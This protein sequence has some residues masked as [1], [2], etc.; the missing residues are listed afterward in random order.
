M[1][2]KGEKMMFIIDLIKA[3]AIITGFLIGIILFMFLY[4]ISIWHF[5]K[6]V[7]DRN[8]E[9]PDDEISVTWIGH[10]TLL[11]N[12]H[13]TKILTDPMYSD[14]ILVFAKRYFEPGVP[15]EKL[16]DIDAIVISHEHYD[17]LD[18]ATLEQLSKDIPVIIRKG[19]SERVKEAGMKDIRELEWWESTE[20]KD[21]RITA[22]PAQHG[23]ANACG[24]VIEGEK[25]FYF[26]GDTGYF[27]A[28]EEIGKKFDLDVAFL[29]MSHYKSRHGR[30][31]VDKMLKRIHMGPA[32]F[33]DAIKDLGVELV[34]P[35]HYLTFRNVGIL[36]LPLDEPPRYMREISKKHGLEKIVKMLDIG[37]K[38]EISG[39][40]KK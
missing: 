31:R 28:F 24:F 35:M 23:R 39:E 3:F 36:E 7:P 40:K 10:A 32:D 19:N 4:S 5:I 37:E 21:V 17:H 2:L 33:P 8:H 34:I 9:W 20:V 14:Y 27:S 15:I 11:V 1:N 18:R 16:P 26:A 22:V 13:G 29:P 12:I 38:I 25:S 6:D 30:E